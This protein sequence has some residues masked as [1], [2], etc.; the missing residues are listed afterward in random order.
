MTNKPEWMLGNPC[1]GCSFDPESHGFKGVCSA[2]E[3]KNSCYSYERYKASNLA[4]IKLLEYL[5]AQSFEFHQEYVVKTVE[6]E[7]MLKQIQEEG[8]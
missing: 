4:Q 6:I 8:K 7:S 2:T 1:K 3:L 5:I